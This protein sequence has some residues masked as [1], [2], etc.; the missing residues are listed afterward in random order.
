MFGA[1]F[2][3]QKPHLLAACIFKT[4][5]RISDAMF[6]LPDVHGFTLEKS[7]SSPRALSFTARELTNPRNLLLKTSLNLT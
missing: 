5:K 6:C 4:S 3:S 2:G 7:T 1:R